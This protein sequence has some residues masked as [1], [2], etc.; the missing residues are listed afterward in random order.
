MPKPLFRVP[1]NLVQEW[2]EIFEDMWIS[3]MPVNY[4]H[5]LQIEFKN[6]RV[7]E[8]NIT[9]QLARTEAEMLSNKLLDTFKE[10]RDSIKKVDFKI[11]V[12]KLKDD[13]LSS[14]KDLL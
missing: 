11:N 4:L 9:E 8:I 3:T 10:Y 1:E 14:T 2:P 12:G 5:T 7:W 13:I 6:G